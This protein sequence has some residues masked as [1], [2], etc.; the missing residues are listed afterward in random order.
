MQYR[1]SQPSHRFLRLVK[2]FWSLEY[3]GNSEPEAIIPDGCIE[4]I[5]NLG[6]RFHRYDATGPTRQ[7]RNLIAGQMRHSVLIAPSGLVRLFGIRFHPLGAHRFFKLDMQE[8]TDRIEPLDAVWNGTAETSE[9]LAA[10]ASHEEQVALAERA[11][12]TRLDPAAGDMRAEMAVGLISRASGVVSIASLAR[13]LEISER[14]LE[15]RFTATI[16]LSPKAFSRIVRFQSVLR[17]IKPGCDLLDLAIA[18]GY[19]DQ[20]HLIADFR[21]FAGTTPKSF[22]ER[23]HVLTD[24]F[25]AD[26]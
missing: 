10:A 22:I 25:I 4:I 7:P 3:A 20:S 23:Q 5:F 8:L 26:A 24:V 1:E 11:L 9:Q 13:E 14:G 2:C 19:Y 21:Q 6:D 16:G 18:H 12:A 15:R 17:S